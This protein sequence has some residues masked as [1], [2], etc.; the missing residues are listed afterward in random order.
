MI[1]MDSKELTLKDI[2]ADEFS[3]EPIIRKPLTANDVGPYA[4]EI[5][6]SVET[7]SNSKL[8]LNSFFYIKISK[9]I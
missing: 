4:E 6:S 3:N 8:N 2:G 7:G 1:L 9:S 5:I